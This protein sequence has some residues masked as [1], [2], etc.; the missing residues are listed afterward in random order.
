MSKPNRWHPNHFPHLRWPMMCLKQINRR[1]KA[2]GTT[3]ELVRI[4]LFEKISAFP[5]GTVKFSIP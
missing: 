5:G 2:E 1:R 3:V 4:E